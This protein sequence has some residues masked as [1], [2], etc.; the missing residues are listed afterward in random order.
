MYAQAPSAPLCLALVE[1][2]IANAIAAR[3][4]IAADTG[5]R[6]A[7]PTIV[8]LVRA[9]RRIRAAQHGMIAEDN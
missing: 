9:R 5:E 7:I 1:R 8:A 2:E 6:R 4:M 3:E